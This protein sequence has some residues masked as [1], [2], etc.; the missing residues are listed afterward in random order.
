MLPERSTLTAHIYSNADHTTQWFGDTYPGDTMP[1]PNCIVIHSTETSTWPGYRGGAT[2][3]NFTV[4]GGRVR[5]HFYANH[6]ARALQNHRGG[7]ETNTLNAVQIELVGTCAKGG[8]G[9]Y[10]PNAED[11]DFD[12]LVGLVRWLTETYPIPLKSV[13]KP[14]RPYPSSYGYSAG[15]RMSNAEWENFYGICGHQHVPENDHGDPGAFPISRLIELVKPTRTVLLGRGSATPIE[16]P[17]EDFLFDHIA[18]GKRGTPDYE[19][20]AW[21]A[22]AVNRSDVTAV[23]NEAAARAAHAAGKHVIAVGGPA[24]DELKD[25]AGVTAV[26]GRNAAHTGEL[27]ARLAL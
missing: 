15:Q 3:P 24:C 12:G 16:V 19:A 1:H 18:Y 5:Q 27:L 25:L 4:K 10:W 8:P 7:V 22:D 2:A 6:S 20:A 14:W 23:S 17:K 26:N 21:W 13:N 9:V 11:D